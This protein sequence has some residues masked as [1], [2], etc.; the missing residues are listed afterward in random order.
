[1]GRPR[2]KSCS[3][4]PPPPIHPPDAARLRRDRHRDHPPD[5]LRLSIPSARRLSRG[6]GLGWRGA[7]PADRLR[8]DRLPSDAASAR[9]ADRLRRDRH[10]RVRPRLPAD[11]AAARPA[12][13]L[14]S[15]RRWNNILTVVK[16]APGKGNPG[17]NQKENI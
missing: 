13:A 12:K 4:G 17:K 7:R 5:A 16:N 1:M 8:R 6:T 9:A 14:G 3:S 2:R 10:R 15:S 11:A